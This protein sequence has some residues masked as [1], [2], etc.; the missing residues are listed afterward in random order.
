[1]IANA[2]ENGSDTPKPRKRGLEI[3]QEEE[4]KTESKCC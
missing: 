3:A 2:S 4:Q 1:M